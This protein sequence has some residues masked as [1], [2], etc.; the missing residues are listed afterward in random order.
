[1]ILKF[2]HFIAYWTPMADMNFNNSSVT[3]TCP[4]Y[5]KQRLPS[6]FCNEDAL[7]LLW[8]RNWMLIYNGYET[9]TMW[10]SNLGK[11]FISRHILHRHWYICPIALPVRQ[12]PHHRVFWLSSQALPQLIS[13]ASSATSESSWEN[14][15]TQLW[16]AL[17]GNHFPP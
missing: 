2:I 7:C 9:Y 17:R 10:Y 11:T 15:S 8:D 6:I 12:N 4:Y 3:T 16:T 14:F 5:P 1:M 13:R